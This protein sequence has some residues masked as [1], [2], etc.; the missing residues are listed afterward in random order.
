[1]HRKIGILATVLFLVFCLALSAQA[2]Q[3]EEVVLDLAKSSIVRE[4]LFLDDLTGTLKPVFTK[5]LLHW[6]HTHDS[7]TANLLRAVLAANVR[8]TTLLWT[9]KDFLLD[10]ELP[11][12]DT[13]M[14]AGG[15]LSSQSLGKAFG[16]LAADALMANADFGQSPPVAAAPQVY[17]IEPKLF[18]TVVDSHLLLGSSADQVEVSRNKLRG[19]GKIASVPDKKQQIWTKTDFYISAAAGG[20]GKFSGKQVSVEYTAFKTERG[21][22]YTGKHNYA[23]VAPSLAGVTPIT[24][25]GLPFLGEAAPDWVLLLGG[26]CLEALGT[27]GVKD[28]TPAANTLMPFPLG[29]IQR[30]GLVI[31]GVKSQLIGLELPGAYC[32]LEGSPALLDTVQVL[33]ESIIP[34]NWQ[35]RPATG[36]DVYRTAD[37][38][39]N[40]GTSIPFPTLIARRGSQLLIGALKHTPAPL[41]RDTPEIFA[42]IPKDARFSMMQTSNTAGFWQEITD[43][44]KPGSPLRA[45]TEIDSLLT[46]VQREALNALLESPLPVK[47][48]TYWTSPDMK[49]T[50]GRVILDEAPNRFIERLCTLIDLFFPPEQKMV[51]LDIARNQLP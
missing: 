2:A 19:G 26:S 50:H 39:K 20:T 6:I 21:W 1:M 15:D 45:L 9:K 13:S 46:P 51:M 30:I 16:E 22:E 31:G 48:F 4:G 11:G 28:V 25:Q 29:E 44:L 23:D 37:L 49:E 43:A 34:G 38:I 35:N 17:Q 7:E 42:V 36:W 41:V 47:Q 5:S 40:K 10:L 33:A 32:F 24:L 14:L 18:Y 8:N 27:I 3:Q 12:G